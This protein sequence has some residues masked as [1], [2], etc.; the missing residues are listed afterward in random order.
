[1]PNWVR[2][3][4]RMKGI[5]D[6][7]LFIEA[8]GRK[9]F[10]FNKLIP[11]PES[12]GIESGSMTNENIIYYLTER[13]TISVRRLSSDKVELLNKLSI[14][15]L[16]DNW[17]EEVF[18]RVMARAF[19]ESEEERQRRY[20]NGKAYGSIEKCTCAYALATGNLKEMQFLLAARHSRCGHI[21]MLRKMLYRRK[22]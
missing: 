21:T 13:C 22:G 7:P 19:D 12:L 10:D 9:V 14:N 3:I 18:H 17:S 15:S 20:D 8:E 16:T 2:N 11:M 1:M 5:A 6:K 4:V